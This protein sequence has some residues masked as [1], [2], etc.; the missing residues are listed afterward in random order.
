MT[1]RTFGIN[2]YRV[3]TDDLIH[4]EADEMHKFSFRNTPPSRM[5]WLLLKC[6]QPLLFKVNGEYYVKVDAQAIQVTTASCFCDAVEFLIKCFY[7]LQLEYPC[8]LKPVYG[9][10][11]HLM[12]IPISIGKKRRYHIFGLHQV[13]SCM[14]KLFQ[15]ILQPPFFVIVCF[16]A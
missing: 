9:L 7:V 5:R 10:F 14:Y 15:C 12:K 13:V 8:E 6:L 2:K 3:S 1:V 4:A 16:T 11:E